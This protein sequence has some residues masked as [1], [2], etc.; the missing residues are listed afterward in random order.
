M[1]PIDEGS[2]YDRGRQLLSDI[3][4]TPTGIPLE[5]AGWGESPIPDGGRR[6]VE[7]HRDQW[8]ARFRWL[9]HAHDYSRQYQRTN[10]GDS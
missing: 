3:S 6:K 9:H 7:G 1:L 10:H 8:P 2:S 4:Q 5:V